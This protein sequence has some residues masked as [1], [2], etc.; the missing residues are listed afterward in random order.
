MSDRQLQAR[1]HA[2]ADGIRRTP[3]GMYDNRLVDCD[4]YRIRY[5]SDEALF[6]EFKHVDNFPM[7]PSSEEVALV[8]ELMNNRDVILAALETLDAALRSEA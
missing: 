3:G 2:L 4:G 1:A 5:E 7:R 6:A 8:V